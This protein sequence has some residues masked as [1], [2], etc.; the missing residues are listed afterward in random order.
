MAGNPNLWPPAVRQACY[1]LR[2]QGL[3][4]TEIP[5]E[6][7]KRFG[8]DVTPSMQTVWRWL[9]SPEAQ[10]LVR[11]AE[12]RIRAI[13]TNETLDLVPSA[14]DG[15]RQALAAGDAKAADASS[16]VIVNLTR[17]FLAERVELTPPKTV[18][19]DAELANLLARHGVSVTQPVIKPD[20]SQSGV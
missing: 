15:L 3:T 19:G 6:L 1:E 10:A 7:A 2:A 8:A 12:S 14:Y 16:R 9:V 20:L 11:E 13:A 5:V 17:G 18:D 4:V